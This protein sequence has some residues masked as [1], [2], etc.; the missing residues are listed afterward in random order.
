MSNGNCK[1]KSQT[2][3]VSRMWHETHTFEVYLMLSCRWLKSRA[4]KSTAVMFF[5]SSSFCDFSLL[6]LEPKIPSRKRSI[7]YSNLQCT[8]Y[9]TSCRTVHLNY[10][11]LLLLHFTVLLFLV[12]SLLIVIQ[13][14]VFDQ[15]FVFV[16][17][18]HLKFH[19]FCRQT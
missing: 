10:L 8:P 4:F 2:C 15:L 12:Q 18:P 3:Q 17:A 13:P 9:S 7:S 19:F 5:F 11:Q 16:F 14:S 1:Y 6:R